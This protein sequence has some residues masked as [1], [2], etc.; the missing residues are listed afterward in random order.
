MPKKF[1]RS[2]NLLFKSNNMDEQILNL[3]C[4]SDNSNSVPKIIESISQE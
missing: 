2:S 4:E 1:K 3:D